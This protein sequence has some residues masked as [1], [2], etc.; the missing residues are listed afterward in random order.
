MDLTNTEA[1]L[2]DAVTMGLCFDPLNMRGKA[3]AAAPGPRGK[4]KVRAPVLRA[5]I[6]G[7]PE[8]DGN[9]PRDPATLPIHMMGVVVIGDLDLSNCR[10]LAHDALPPILFEY[11]RFSGEID[12][13][14]STLSR[15]SLK[16]SR[17]KSL[18]GKG[19][20][21]FNDVCLDEVASSAYA[22]DDDNPL[23]HQELFKKR[24]KARSAQGEPVVIS[25]HALGRCHIELNN[26][27]IEGDVSASGAKLC[28]EAGTSAQKE[29]AT[30]PYALELAGTRVDGSLVLISGFV[31]MGGLRL[32]ETVVKG[33]IWLLGAKLRAVNI[34]EAINGQSLQVGEHVHLRAGH[35]GSPFCC[36][37]GIGLSGANIGGELRL[38]GGA[39][40][41]S[42]PAVDA[43]GLA[44][45][46]GVTLWMAKLGSAL[47]GQRGPEDFPA[48]TIYNGLCAPDCRTAHKFTFLADIPA[49]DPKQPLIAAHFTHENL[50]SAAFTAS[51]LDLSSMHV[52]GNLFVTGAKESRARISGNVRLAEGVVEGSVHINWVQIGDQSNSSS[53][54]LNTMTV[55]Q[56]LTLGDPSANDAVTIHGAVTL[57]GTSCRGKIS[58]VGCR[59]G[60]NAGISHVLDATA[61]QSQGDMQISSEFH[62]GILMQRARIEGELCLGSSEEGSPP[63]K[64][65]WNNM[66]RT[67]SET[68]IGNVLRFDLTQTEIH[69]SLRVNQLAIS[70][71][72]E[73]PTVRRIT[74][75]RVARP[76]CYPGWCL[77]EATVPAADDQPGNP[78]AGKDKQPG[79]VSYLVDYTLKS[80]WRSWIAELSG[81]SN[82]LAEL[83]IVRLDGN[84]L[85]L[86]RLNVSDWSPLRLRTKRQASD[87]LRLF[88]GNVWGDQGPFMVI[89]HASQLPPPDKPGSAEDTTPPA[90]TELACIRETT[91]GVTTYRFDK[92]FIHYSDHLFEAK[93]RVRPDGMVEMLEDK[94]VQGG[95][96]VP[97]TAAPL[98]MPAPPKTT[99]S[100][101]LS[102]ALNYA[103]ITADS[104]IWQA[105]MQWEARPERHQAPR[106]FEVD[107]TG[108]S[109]ASLDDEDGRAWSKE[110]PRANQAARPKGMG[111]L[112]HSLL[113]LGGFFASL[114]K[115]EPVRILG[116]SR[117]TSPQP[118]VW[119]RLDGLRFGRTG[120][121]TPDKV[122]RGTA[123][124]AVQVLFTQASNTEQNEP[125]QV[126]ARRREW[127]LMQYANRLYPRRDRSAFYDRDISLGD[128]NPQPY[129]ELAKALKS[130]GDFAGADD[131]MVFRSEMDNW[132]HFRSAR[133]HRPFDRLGRKL[134]QALRAPALWF[135]SRGFAYGMKPYRAMITF[136]LFILIG[137]FGVAWANTGRPAVLGEWMSGQP[138]MVIDAE[139]M[140]AAIAFGSEWR[141]GPVI[142]DGVTLGLADAAQE[143]PCGDE[144]NE[145]LYAVDLFIPLLD[146]RQET[147][148]RISNSSGV[149]NW[150]KTVYAIF[151]WIVTSLTILTVSGVMRRRSAE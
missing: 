93:M 87:Y 56:M 149:W 73:V 138:V 91:D 92:V 126:L 51:D 61:L 29:A 105:I 49:V 97:R 134:Y 124:S 108:V 37:G 145:A 45:S 34:A 113:G 148:C 132:L 150:I 69:H 19:C 123:Q 98:L 38:A 141:V 83:D 47:I 147:E 39:V 54:W 102:P 27:I 116:A 15:L 1:A 30:L 144:I 58:I 117:Q 59:I 43:L 146:L 121:T 119:L 115:W 86:H 77:V 118:A 140:A 101:Q 94:P 70:H 28:C 85:P 33:S 10:G 7:S 139:P 9:L 66:W 40:L 24:G 84:S 106:P 151:G 130:Q 131:I 111:G 50:A 26:A 4:Y 3:N 53:A 60:I 127:L 16:G 103:T 135:F 109:A 100:G 81:R 112:W 67:S 21:I 2:R 80:R 44:P 11:C 104:A 75:M 122:T 78:D 55:G 48:T 14:H 63:L 96:P 46:W 57:Q 99:E 36:I 76:A 35:D 42:V 120:R 41:P 68:M 90:V 23:I 107:L 129:E 65:V 25:G 18:H 13:D 142:L 137:W 74:S 128:F 95:L 31:A 136:A 62:G 71:L 110:L 17:L 32:R 12:L 72:G 82:P 5:L 52:G 8:I 64:L 88:S 125:E 143:I 6:A 133:W 79:V 20:H 89:E 114:W 22:R